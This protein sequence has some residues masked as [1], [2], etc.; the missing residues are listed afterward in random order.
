[1]K[2]SKEDILFSKLVRERAGWTCERCLKYYP[3]GKRQGLHCSHIWGRARHSVRWEPLN[4]LA[5]CY[6]CH[7]HVTS[8]PEVHKILARD[9]LGEEKYEH[10]LKLANTTRKW[11]RGEKEDLYQ[12]MKCELKRMESLRSNG[13]RSRL[14]FCL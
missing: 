7:Q 6:G 2:R 10:L 12:K 14:E 11:A 3:E 9:V 8:H 13:S 5:L 1:M 4:A